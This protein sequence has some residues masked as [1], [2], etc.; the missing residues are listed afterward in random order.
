MRPSA[1]VN[2]TLPL[3]TTLFVFPYSSNSPGKNFTFGP[4]ITARSIKWKWSPTCSSFQLEELEM[5]S[6][7][8]IVVGVAGAA[9]GAVSAGGEAGVGAWANATVAHIHAAHASRKT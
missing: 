5:P 4:S 6:G 7:R 8:L 1:L 2:T 3:A 9:G